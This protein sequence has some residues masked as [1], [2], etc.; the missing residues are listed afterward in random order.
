MT[1]DADARWQKNRV[2]LT[3]I[4]LTIDRMID[5]DSFYNVI[6]KNDIFLFEKSSHSAACACND[7]YQ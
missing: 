7:W 4:L 5:R 3:S 1:L 6:S 2:V